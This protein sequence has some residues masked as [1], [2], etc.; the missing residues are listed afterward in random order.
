MRNAA[1]RRLKS[2]FAVVGEQRV[3]ILGQ[4]TRTEHFWAQIPIAVLH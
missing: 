1:D 2:S 3:V 4:L